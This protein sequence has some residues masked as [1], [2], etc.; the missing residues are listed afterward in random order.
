MKIDMLDE[1]SEQDDSDEIDTGLGMSS[2]LQFSEND[3][4]IDF[5]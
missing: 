4:H 1:Q 5:Y 2:F 3:I